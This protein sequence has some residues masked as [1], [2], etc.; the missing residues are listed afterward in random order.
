MNHLK[1]IF[2]TL[3][4]VLRGYFMTIGILVTV[5]P[6]LLS[7][8]ALRHSHSLSLGNLASMNGA[9]TP[10]R[11]ETR[12]EWTL[13]GELLENSPDIS[14]RFL[15]RFFQRQTGFYLPEIRRSLRAAASDKHIKSL[16]LNVYEIHGS[17]AEFEELRRILGDFRK[18]GKPVYMHLSTLDDTLLYLAS[19]A[20]SVIMAPAGE[21][22]LTGPTFNLTYFGEALKKIGASVE[23]V[24]H[25]KYKSAFEPFV[26]NKPSPETLEM[27]RTM[28]SS[29]LDHFVDKIAEGRKQPREKVASWFK[30]GIFTPADAV[31][32]GIVD[33]LGYGDDA[34]DRL[35]AA[36]PSKAEMDFEDFMAL[37]GEPSVET[38]DRGKKGATASEKSGGQ[39]GLALIEAVGEIHMTGSNSSSADII[40]A[41]QMVKELRWAAGEPDAKAVVIRIS[42]PGGSATAS[43]LIWREV[44]ALSLEKPVIV[45]MGSYAASGGYYIAAPAS[46]IIAEPSTIT[47]SIGV[48]GMNIKLAEVEKKF[49]LSFH[50]ITSSDRAKLLNP[51]TPSSPEDKALLARAVDDVYQTFIAKVADGRDLPIEQVE[52]IAQGRVYTGIQAEK[53]ELVDELGGLT[54]AFR[55]AKEYAGL[56]TE[57]LYPILRYEADRPS[58]MDCL[59]GP[60]GMMECLE[61]TGTRLRQ[62]FDHSVIATAAPAVLGN[63]L[64]R[65]ARVMKIAEQDRIMALWPGYL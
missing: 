12:L 40:T 31:S 43:D 54:D 65:T 51:S 36:A 53:L 14:T 4:R 7:W 52:R 57:K 13:N 48:I 32:A 25:G 2:G 1:K 59:S 11:K 17:S 62:Q 45:S 34:L 26:S 41:E 27:Y 64:D 61:F 46:W 5:L 58:L 23:V 63:T 19:A 16:M 28:E 21:I 15:E 18:S 29:L 3:G 30:R 44:E 38:S 37:P 39:A 10:P 42:S 35:E 24:R 55:A 47:G 6:V 9:V 22:T 50:T 56:D 8:A 60:L 33:A 49:G 20:D